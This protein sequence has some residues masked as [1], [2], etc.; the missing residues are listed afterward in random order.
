MPLKEKVMKNKKNSPTPGKTRKAPAST[1][2][3]NARPQPKGV[4]PSVMTNTRA[5]DRGTPNTRRKRTGFGCSLAVA[6]LLV[7]LGLLVVVGGPFLLAFVNQTGATALALDDKTSPVILAERRIQELAQLQNYGWVDKA[8]GVAHIPVARAITLLAT[9]GL[10][11]GGPTVDTSGA[12]TGPT[13]DLSNVNYEDNIQPLF[14]QHCGKCHGADEPD[15]GLQLTTYKG[16]MLGSENGSVVKPGDP[17][18]SYLVEEVVTG[19]MPKKAP[20]LPQNEIDLIIA[21]I[22]VG[23]PEKGDPNAA[24][25][26]AIDPASV[27]FARDVLPLFQESCG[28]CHGA[29]EPDE[30]LV[31]T[32]Y[33]DVMAGSIYGAVIKP[34]AP[35]DSYLVELVATGQMPK[36]GADLTPAQVDIIRAW[37]QAGALDN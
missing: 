10:P 27:S 30:G 7:G 8:A 4:T 13:V 9:S 21:W 25:A 19:K 17:D 29:E 11:V 12:A 16:V 26:T 20:D 3:R 33:K 37:I 2:Q 18:K 31:L 22:K 35:D 5:P 23:A 36:R 28:K 14:E 15:A 6:A 34:G 32:S 1:P 24:V